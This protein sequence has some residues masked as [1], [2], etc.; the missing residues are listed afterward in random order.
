MRRILP[1]ILLLSFTACNK[2]FEKGVEP[3]KKLVRY[4]PPNATL[5]AGL[6][7]QELTASP[8]YRRHAQDIDQHLFEEV[9]AQLGV[10]PRKDVSEALF[11][12]DSRDPIV[13]AHGRFEGLRDKSRVLLPKPDVLVVAPKLPGQDTELSP[14]MRQRL[15]QVPKGDQLWIVSSQGLPLNSLPTSSGTRSALSNIS[16]NIQAFSIGIGADEGVRLRGEF[17]CDS[18]AGAK[19]VHDA[20]RGLIGMGRLMTRDDQLPLLKLYDAIQVDQDRSLVHVHA[21]LDANEAD[22]AI[23]LARSFRTR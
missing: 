1:F 18:D 9:R 8:L 4:L 5:L 7:V 22:A 16:N 15:E 17:V 19:R 6:N 2:S 20:L 10:D 21:D 23:A 13:L 3:D 12:W 11:T 14:A